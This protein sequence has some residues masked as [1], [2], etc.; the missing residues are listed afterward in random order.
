MA[1]DNKDIQR[2]NEEASS[3]E[4]LSYQGLFFDRVHRALLAAIP[5]DSRP[6]TIVD[7]GCGT[8]RLLRRLA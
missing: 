6:E 4:A 3:Y 7:I 1:A 8:G 5:P 2:F